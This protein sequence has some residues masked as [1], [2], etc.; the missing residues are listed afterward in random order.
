MKDVFATLQL[1]V[2]TTIEGLLDTI[3]SMLEACFSMPETMARIWPDDEDMQ[4]RARVLARNYYAA[5]RE[6]NTTMMDII[7][8]QYTKAIATPKKEYDYEDYC[9]REYAARVKSEW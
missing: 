7:G 3:D 6:D 4:S 9:M 1:A 5:R 2:P 8:E